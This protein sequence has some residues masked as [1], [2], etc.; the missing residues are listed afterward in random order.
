MAGDVTLVNQTTSTTVPAGSIATSYNT[1]T[2]RQ[3][4]TFP[5]FAASV[6]PNGNYRATITA[7]GVTDIAGNPLGADN[8]LDFF[9]LAGD[10]N[11]DATVDVSDLGISRPTGRRPARRSPTAISTTTASLTCRT[12]EFSSPTGRRP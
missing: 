9:I 3:T 8:V 1:S 2:N 12:W 11:H 10:A 7:A 6:L 5:G 4:V